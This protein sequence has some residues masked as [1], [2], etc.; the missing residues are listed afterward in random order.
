[1]SRFDH[2]DRENL[3]YKLT[4]ER[5]TQSQSAV[6]QGFGYPR[7]VSHTAIQNE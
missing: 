3:V 7:S 4:V 2:M 5:V 1:M 6:E